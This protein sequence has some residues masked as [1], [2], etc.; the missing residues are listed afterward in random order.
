[1]HLM[2]RRIIYHPEVNYALRQ[3]LVLCLPVALGW[4]IDEL[5]KGLLLSFVPA[6]CN[7]AGLDTLHKHFFRRLLIGGSLFALSSFLVQW[8]PHVGI[9]LPITLFIMALVLGIVGE[10][11]ALYAR[12]LP[13]SLIA[14]VFTLSLSGRMPVWEPPLF[15]VIGT[16]WYGV[17]NWIWFWIWK[18]QP[19]RETLSLLYQQLANYCDEKYNFQ[20][21]TNPEKTLPSLRARQQKIVDLINTCYEQ[22][23]M[24]ANTNNKRYTYL[25][26]VFQIALDLQEHLSISFHEPEEE[27]KFSAWRHAEAIVRWNAK[28]ITVRLSQLSKDV[29]YHH[30][31]TPFSMEKPLI[32][33]KKLTMQ[34]S[35]NQAANFYYYYFSRISRILHTQSPLY[36]RDLMADRQRHLPLIP[37]I[38]SYCSLKSPALRTAARFATMLTFGSTLTLVFNIPK[39]YWILM[40]TMLVCQN[41]YNATRTRIQHRALGTLAGLAIS[42]VTLHILV[43]QAVELLALL[44]ITLISY[45]FIRKYYGWATIGFTITAVYSLQLLSLDGARFLLPRLIDTLIGCLIAFA[46]MTWLWPQWQSGLLRRNAHDALDAY[47]NALSMLLNNEPSAEK[48]AYQRIRVNQRHNALFNSLAQATQEPAFNTDYLSDM[49]SWVSHSQSIVEHINAMTVTARENTLLTP[50]LAKSYLKTCEIA[51]QR[52][53]HRLDYDDSDL[54]S[55]DVPGT[56]QKEQFSAFEHHIKCILEHLNV[57]HT[58][59]SLVWKQR[60]QHGKWLIRLSR[61]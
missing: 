60:P 2:W 23:H 36:R 37:A 5:Q 46:G 33:L 22:I 59:S 52:C 43:P 38:F 14:A 45:L 54:N 42:G 17:F 44:V 27:K 48:L 34:Y 35:G 8:M 1:M 32:A 16:I 11:G 53:Q 41:S 47:K 25:S 3:T 21:R 18:E 57:M 7:I 28:T 10:I 50:T 26:Y 51:L 30:P 55:L 29:L 15:Y 49:K 61:H 9:P 20:T 6:C 4:A 56:Q 19:M 31:S 13:A 24:L 58:I 40:T 12:L 39:S